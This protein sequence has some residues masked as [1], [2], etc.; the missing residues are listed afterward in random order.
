MAKLSIKKANGGPRLAASGANAGMT[1]LPRFIEEAIEVG[2]T[3]LVSLAKTSAEYAKVKGEATGA[4]IESLFAMLD[5]VLSCLR[6]RKNGAKIKGAEIDAVLL[7]SGLKEPR[8]KRDESAAGFAVGSRT[9][10]T[11]YVA[12]VQMQHEALW[13]VKKA[14][15]L[16]FILKGSDTQP[17]GIQFT[18]GGE[19]FKTP[20]DAIRGG[21]AVTTAHDVFARTIR[22]LND[23]EAPPVK[24]TKYER[25]VKQALNMTT[26]EREALMASLAPTVPTVET[27]EA[28]NAA[29][30]A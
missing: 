15:A 5:D 30:Q 20:Y 25:L 24:V 27:V 29:A 13:P 22:S 26:E 6:A 17:A 14:N 19:R 28:P 12:L 1:D 23:Q 3:A 2:H 11:R 9:G 16:R 18:A 4:T 7:K 21:I 10:A 8:I